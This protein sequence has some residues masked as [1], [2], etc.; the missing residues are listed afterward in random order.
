MPALFIAGQIF[1]TLN[2]PGAHRVQVDV[3]RDF[4]EIFLTFTSGL[5]FMLSTQT[6]PSAYADGQES[7]GSD[8]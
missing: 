6:K 8:N 1:I 5:G 4:K 2:Q 7:S 3:C